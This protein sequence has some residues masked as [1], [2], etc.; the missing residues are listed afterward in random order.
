MSDISKKLITISENQQK[1]YE[2]GKQAERDE[3]WDRMQP[4]H[5]AGGVARAAFY[6]WDM[7]NFKPKRNIRLIPAEK[8]ASHMFAYTKTYD[9]TTKKYTGYS[10]VDLLNQYGVKL[11]TT[12]YT[13]Y[14][15]MFYGSKVTEVP[16]INISGATV[17]DGM[18]AECSMLTTI[19]ELIVSSSTPSMNNCFQNCVN[20]KNLTITGT[21]GKRSA[22][23]TACT[24]LS[25]DSIE[26]IIHAL[27][28]TTSG[29][30]V[31]FSEAA[32]TEAFGSTES[33]EWTA[34]I[35]TKSNWTI[36][37]A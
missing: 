36:S 6:N 4:A 9:F 17:I 28:S 26:S 12:G 29:L 32:V 10:L 18:F 24:K 15:Q 31:G 27:S 37:L 8:D 20:L 25:R 1:V 16:S 35:A 5:L 3:F 7:A 34:L 13:N 11:I 14:Q 33:D 30:A 21:I 23:F 22:N 2:A 19:E